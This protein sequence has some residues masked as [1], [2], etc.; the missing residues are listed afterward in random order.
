MVVKTISKV[1]VRDR[2]TLQIKETAQA[3]D[4]IDL[5]VLTNVDLDVINSAIKEGTDKVYK[6]KLAEVLKQEA[7]KRESAVE[8]AES[9]LAEKITELNKTIESLKK[10]NDSALKLQQAELA[11][12]YADQISE[13]KNTIANLK[14]ETNSS[15]ELALK[16]AQL[17]HQKEIQEI[18][19]A[20]AKELSSK[21]NIIREKE[22]AFLMLQ[23]QKAALNVKQTGEDLEA[24]CNNEV[25]SYMQNGLNNCTW[26]KDNE[27]I[28]DEGEAKGSKADYIFK[29]YATRMHKD[30]ELLASI[31]LEMKDENPDSK[32]RK[33]NASYYAA[34]DKNRIKKG[35][36]YAV[37]VSNLETDKP[38]DLP[39]F[40]VNEYQDMYVVRP[41]YMMTFLNMITS[42]TTRF[43]EMII[44]DNEH[45]IELQS[46]LELMTK[47]EELKNTYLDKPLESLQKN[48][49]ELQKQNGYIMVA[50]NKIS[51]TCGTIINT[52][53][54]GIQAKLSNFE[55]K[56]TREYKRV[57]GKINFVQQSV[58]MNNGGQA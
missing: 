52:Y 43:S 50:S 53:I 23:R 41:A 57:D 15:V 2:N 28:T 10:E 36:K 9:K 30:E 4:I 47:F 42:L 45:K 17:V 26:S 16:E 32:N 24:W 58:D 19:E 35:C 14:K 27:V 11:K 55:I 34:L 44:A 20:H 29:I 25:A 5:S 33:T 13:L 12:Q 54:Q 48:I 38:N 6:E 1:I 37:L 49:D 39:I 40:K 18:K 21:D 22:E 46:S 51:L 8:L 31:C 56:M 3:D 7:L